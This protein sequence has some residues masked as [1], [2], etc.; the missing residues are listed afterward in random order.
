[1]TTVTRPAL[2][3]VLAYTLQAYGITVAE[4]AQHMGQQLTPTR[5]GGPSVDTD[6]VRRPAPTPAPKSLPVALGDQ[7]MQV[8]TLADRPEGDTVAQVQDLLGVHYATAAYHCDRLARARRLTKAKGRGE[9]AF[10]F[11]ARPAQAAAYVEARQA[12]TDQQAQADEQARQ[13]REQG[14]KERAEQRVAAKLAQQA[15]REQARAQAAQD[16][17]QKAAASVGLRVGRRTPSTENAKS[18]LT[19]SPPKIDDSRMRPQGEAV[20]TAATR[21]TVDATARPTARWQAQDLPADPRWPS[22]S[23]APLGCDPA[24]GKPWE[25]RA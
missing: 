5:P 12:E 25:R 24:T 8:I 6:A 13:Q 3:S 10:R 15:Q 1:M 23:S 11:F 14:R 20:E 16:K 19:L 17:A 4:L 18:N 22:F 2:L 21:R 9:H 7:A